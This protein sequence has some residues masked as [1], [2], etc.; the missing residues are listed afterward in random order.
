ML[1]LRLH[2]L[3]H[4]TVEIHS[5][6]CWAEVGEVQLTGPEI[7]QETT[8]KII[9]VKQRMQAAC[10]RQKSYADLKRKPMEFEVGDKVMLRFR[11]GKGVVIGAKR[12]IKSSLLPRVLTVEMRIPGEEQPCLLLITSSSV[13]GLVRG[14]CRTILVLDNE[15]GRRSA[16]GTAKAGAIQGDCTTLEEGQSRVIAFGTTV[17]GDDDHILLSGLMH[18]SRGDRRVISDLMEAGLSETET[19]PAKDPAEPELPEEASSKVFDWGYDCSTVQSISIM[20]YSQLADCIKNGTKRKAHEVKPRCNSPTSRDLL[21]PLQ[22]SCPDLGHDGRGCHCVFGS[23]CYDRN[24]DDSIPREQV[25]IRNDRC[26][27]VHYQDFMKMFNHYSSGARRVVDM[28]KGTLEGLPPVENKNQGMQ[29][30]LRQNPDNNVVRCRNNVMDWLPNTKQLLDCAKKISSIFPLGERNLNFSW[31][32]KMSRLFGTSYHQGDWRKSKKQQLQ[33]VPM[34][35]TFPEVLSKDLPGLHLPESGLAHQSST[36][37]E[38]VI[39]S[40]ELYELFDQFKGLGVYSK[41]DLGQNNR[42]ARRALEDNIGVLKKEVVCKNFPSVNFGFPRSIEEL[43]I[44]I[45][46]LSSS[47]RSEDLETLNGNTLRVQALVMTISLDLAKQILNAQTE[48]R[49]PENIN[50]ED[51][52]GMLIENAKFPEA[53]RTEKLEPRIDGTLCLNG[54]SWL[55]A[56]LMPHESPLYNVHSLGHDEGSMQQNE[57]MDLV[58]KLS[59]RV[60]VL[61]TDIQQTKKVYSSTI[62][63]LILTV[64]KLEKT[65]KT[66]KARRRA[67]QDTEYDFDATAS[68]HVTTVGL[69]IS[70]AN[71]VVSTADAAVTIASITPRV[72]VSRMS[73]SEFI[74]YV[75][76]RYPALMREPI[77]HGS[78]G[79]RDLFFGFHHLDLCLNLRSQM[80]DEVFPAEEQPMPAVITYIMSR[81][82]MRSNL[83]HDEMQRRSTSSCRHPAT[84]AYS[85]DQDP[86]HAYR[87]HARMSID[88]GAKHRSFSRKLLERLLALPTSTHHSLS[89]LITTSSDTLSGIPIPPPPD[90][91][92][93]HIEGILDP[94]LLGLDTRDALHISSGTAR[95]VGP[96]TV[97]V[98]LY[99]FADM[100]DA[101]PGCQTTRELG[102]GITDIWDDLVGAIQEI[103]TDHPR[104]V[105]QRARVNMLDR[106]RP[107]HRCTAIL[108]EEEAR[109]SRAAWAQSMD[110]CNQTC[111]E[112]IS[113]RT[114]VMAQKS[115]ITELQAADRRRQSVISDLLKAD[116]R[117]KRQL[118]R[119]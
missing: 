32:R 95:Q 49:K 96:A 38:N 15:V 71:I 18:E 76:W 97:R 80:D 13:L 36:S 77:R 46:T 84:V 105:N 7:V 110:A 25:W 37:E 45:W 26:L 39:R 35:K 47:V 62:T 55:R 108:M 8:E 42:R 40:Q 73:D 10:D 82:M 119:H 44:M 63:K 60:T 30:D 4:F 14:S 31:R 12:E 6:V 81:G 69:E 11:L 20:G 98:D 79:S 24:G 103:A 115:E 53:L 34:S 68:I 117:E 107:F 66:T 93:L 118:L 89:I 9:Q 5:P 109:L 113:L 78:P 16:A 92:G 70:N 41:I 112:G 54:R 85:A 23:T 3:R 59:E 72:L 116:Y 50:N 57:L 51:V 100:L 21:P 52:G 27:G 58:T 87:V 22:S 17:D 65:I 2:P 33:D 61:E 29:W 75:Y 86:Y 43:T 102:Y 90:L 1:A 56:D 91:N 19:G 83:M 74:S 88:L 28:T 104:G 111:S 114:T 99:G 101:T 67:K 94:E 106:D 48:A 64:K